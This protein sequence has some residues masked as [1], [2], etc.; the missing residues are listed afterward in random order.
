MGSSNTG[1]S[2]MSKT[3]ERK[4]KEEQFKIAKDIE[5][6]HKNPN[7]E[8]L[9]EKLQVIANNHVFKINPEG[10]L[11]DN[12]Q[13][14]RTIQNKYKS[15]L[16]KALQVS[17]ILEQTDIYEKASKEILTIGL[18]EFDYNAWANHIDIGPTVLGQIATEVAHF[19]VVQGGKAGYRHW[20]T[21]QKL[22]TL[23]L[24]SLSNTS[25]D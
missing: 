11:L 5:E 6:Y 20:Q 21:Q 25:K 23:T 19:L 13:K 14:I 24:S 16:K 3:V 1:N 22:E 7:V 12:K 4:I 17:D 10:H 18:I 9:W 15:D 2:L 8:I